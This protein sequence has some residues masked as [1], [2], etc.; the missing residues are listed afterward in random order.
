MGL[1]A[2]RRFKMSLWAFG[3]RLQD[4]DVKYAVKTGAATA[5]LAAP[6]FFEATR[7][8]FMEYRGE[9][10]LIS[11]SVVSRWPVADMV[12]VERTSGSSFVLVLCR[13]VSHNRRRKFGLFLTLI[14]RRVIRIGCM[15]R[16]PIPL[17]CIAFSGHCERIM[18]L[19]PVLRLQSGTKR[20]PHPPAS[21]SQ[22][23][24]RD[25][26]DRVHVVPQDPG[27]VGSVRVLL[28]D[29]VLL[30]HRRQTAIR[31]DWPVRPP[32]VQLDVSILVSTTSSIQPP[33]DRYNRGVLMTLTGTGCAA[34][35]PAIKQTDTTRDSSKSPSSTSLSI[36]PPPSPSESSGPALSRGS[37]G[38]PRRAGNSASS[39]ES[40]IP[41][42]PCLCSFLLTLRGGGCLAHRFCLN[43][44][45]L[46]TRLVA[47]NSFSPENPMDIAESDESTED[48]ALLPRRLN[49]SVEE[50]MAMYDDSLR[51]W[52]GGAISDLTFF[53]QGVALAN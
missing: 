50:F 43:I 34:A 41:G 49:N 33:R 35:S 26:G 31:D 14:Q 1:S 5:I 46:Y 16:R 8:T 51:L 52:C 17:A 53:P 38:R 20:A 6:A 36:A 15:T 11:V 21:I 10:A 28:L 37:G 24:C 9:W 27:R 40:T 32:D 44:G 29:A 23:R 18:L 12:K 13:H 45:W 48:T 19:P 2:W 25:R 4:H 22:V 3:G 30:L 39:W 7:P 47:S 42:F